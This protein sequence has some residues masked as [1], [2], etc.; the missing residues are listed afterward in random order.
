MRFRDS[1][2]AVPALK[3]D[4]PPGKAPDQPSPQTVSSSNDANTA[5]G[6]SWIAGDTRVANDIQVR[7]ESPKT[8]QAYTQW[9]RH[10]QT[11][12]RS[13]DPESL[14]SADVREFLTCLAVTKKV[15]ASTQ[16]LAFN[17][18][19]CFDRYVLNQEFG[20]VEGVVRAKRKPYVPGVLSREEM[21]TILQYWPPPYDLVVKLLYGC[22]LRLSACL[23]LRVQCCNVD[24][25]V[26]TI[27]DGKGGKDRTVPRPETILPAL[28][29]QLASLKD[30]HQRDLERDYAGVLLVNA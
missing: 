10:V 16:N 19:L 21:A 17:A 22:G 8:L 23:Q 27:H 6:V 26:F 9:V 4:E 25:G 29:A 13:Q 28:R 18:L 15:S 24:V 5:T 20:T 1:H 3:R 2:R 14:S 7:H 11:L 30:L 12:T